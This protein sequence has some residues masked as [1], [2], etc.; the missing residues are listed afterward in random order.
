MTGHNGRMDDAVARTRL[1]VV[2]FVAW[3]AVLL[4]LGVALGVWITRRGEEPFAIDVWWNSVLAVGLS[5]YLDV[6]SFV[7]NF[8]GGGWFGAIVLPIG[9]AVVLLV[10]RR[11]WSAAYF[12]AAQ[13]VSAGIVQVLKHT[14]ARVRP[15]EIL[16]L[17][18]FGSFPSGHVAGAATLMT[19]I[20]VVFPRWF[21]VTLGAFY[22]AAMAFSR[23]Y[24]HAHW[25]SD[26]LGGALVGV[27]AALLVAA[28]FAVPLAREMPPR[29]ADAAPALG[30]RA[31]DAPP[32]PR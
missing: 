17:S 16:V 4:A 26:T 14:F 22:V 15:D 9:G 5:A 18:D 12:L 32:V 13:A 24:L 21:I 7:M 23:T 10:L 20:A 25:L 11:T 2:A 19:A 31:H 1:P 29:D 6:F 30:A 8:V 28:A 3:G 27:G